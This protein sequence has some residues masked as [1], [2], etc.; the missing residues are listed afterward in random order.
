MA[1]TVF[2]SLGTILQSDTSF[3]SWQVSRYLS[4]TAST[5]T[6]ISSSGYTTWQRA[7]QTLTIGTL[8]TTTAAFL[9]Y[10]RMWNSTTSN[11]TET[12]L[13]VVN[14]TM[15]FNGST[16]S[17]SSGTT[18]PNRRIYGASAATQWASSKP[19]LYVSTT[20][21]ATTPAI[22]IT[23][24]NQAGTGS[25]TT[26]AITLP[27]NS[28]ANSAFNLAPFLQSGDTGIQSVQNIVTTGGA[29]GVIKVASLFPLLYDTVSVSGSTIAQPLT[30][31]QVL[32]PLLA[33]DVISFWKTGTNASFSGWVDLTFL[34]DS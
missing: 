30:N 25:R 13:E 15:T 9:S 5:T 1:N 14:G 3:G 22:T 17:F 31:P 23:Y 11:H 7:P 2:K 32:Y 33:N 27:T 4:I 28:V 10:G 6:A 26:S 34:G 29:S 24:T 18:N 12:A 20:L 19:M 21:T 16:G 8:T